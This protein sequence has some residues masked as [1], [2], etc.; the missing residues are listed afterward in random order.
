[1]KRLL[2][3][4]LLL[5]PVQSFGWGKLNL[6]PKLNPQGDVFAFDG[7]L[8]VQESLPLPLVNYDSFVGI[9]NTPANGPGYH[10]S[11]VTKQGLF[12]ELGKVKVEPAYRV[13]YFNDESFWRH[14]VELGISY[15]LWD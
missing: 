15:R 8:S 1:M 10:Y 7:G 14:E 2:F 3:A 4:L 9:E 11:Y 13:R 5:L 6:T 12:F